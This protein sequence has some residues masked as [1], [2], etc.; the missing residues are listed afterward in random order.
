M[1]GQEG[2][3]PGHPTQPLQPCKRAGCI[4]QLINC[5]NPTLKNIK[6]FF[7]FFALLRSCHGKAALKPYF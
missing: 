6:L 3:A 1:L 5:L 4:I 7:F 2:D